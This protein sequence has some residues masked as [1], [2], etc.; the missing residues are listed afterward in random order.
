MNAARLAKHY[1]ALTAWERTAAILAAAARDDLAEVE[2]LA[3]AAL[4][5]GYTVP[6]HIGHLDGVDLAGFLYLARQLDLAC[7]FEKAAGMLD[8]YDAEAH[9]AKTRRS[10]DRMHNVMRGVA[11][12]MTTH[13]EAWRRLCG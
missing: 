4:R 1:D 2:R 11:Y 10:A 3:R 7:Q 6:H 8:A 9:D 12:V 13:A 5:C